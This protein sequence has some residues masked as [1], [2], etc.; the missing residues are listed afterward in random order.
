MT[1]SIP[2]FK[3]VSYDSLAPGTRLVITGAVHGNETCGTRAIERVLREIDAGEIVI[4]AGSVT[5]VPI[6]NPLAYAKRER[7]GDRNLNRN[8]FPKE[9]PVDFEDRVANALCPLLARHEALL[10]L[11]STRGRTEPFALVGPPDNDGPVEPFRHSAKERALAR[12]LGV[13]RFVQGWLSTYARGVERR[14]R[15]GSGTSANSDARYGVG[16]TE[17]MRSV[18]GYAITLECGQHDEPG[19]VDVAYRAI[20]N[21]LAFLGHVEDPPPPPVQ[22]YE[23]LRIQ[24]VIDRAHPG[25]RFE[26]E[27]A[28]FDSLA[29]GDVIAHRHDGTVLRAG[30]RG[31]ILFP[32]VGAKPGNEWYYLAENVEAI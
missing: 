26:R 27:W 31:R 15:E 11:H 8:L 18:G 12:R 23:A 20:R 29:P 28:S 7:S 6:V 10:D 30:A 14:R 19:A 17:F 13:K 2:P 1:V 16:T 5:F 4:A 3:S 32:D 21:A 22:A 24:E 25:D 9:N